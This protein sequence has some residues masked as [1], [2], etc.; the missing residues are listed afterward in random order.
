[1]ARLLAL[2]IPTISLVIVFGTVEEMYP[3][4]LAQFASMNGSDLA[5]WFFV[6]PAFIATLA[7]WNVPSSWLAYLIAVEAA[8]FIPNVVQII[9]MAEQSH[10][11][12]WIGL[13]GL[14]QLIWLFCAL[15]IGMAARWLWKMHQANRVEK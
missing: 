8:V 4:W 9:Y 13:A 12:P 14:Y 3:G 2:L 11:H 10:S 5:D 7:A 1:M 15:V 6:A